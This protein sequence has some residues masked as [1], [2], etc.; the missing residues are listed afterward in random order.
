MTQLIIF[1]GYYNYKLYTIGDNLVYYVNTVFE[2]VEKV[3]DIGLY[4]S[5]SSP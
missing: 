2:A 4:N 5:C 3:L 1:Y